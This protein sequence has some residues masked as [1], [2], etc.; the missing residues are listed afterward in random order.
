MM[1]RISFENLMVQ[2]LLA[3][4]RNFCHG[5][6]DAHMRNV[7]IGARSPGREVEAAGFGGLPWFATAPSGTTNAAPEVKV[8]R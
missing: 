2:H 7:A 6:N 8:Y 1:V 3:E 4:G 5:V